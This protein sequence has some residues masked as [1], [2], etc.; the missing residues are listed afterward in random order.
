[1][2]KQPKKSRKKKSEFDSPWKAIIDLYFK[3]FMALCWPEKHAIID[4][5]KGYTMLDKDLIKIDKNAA[6]SN[7]CVD[8]LIEIHCI[9]GEVTYLILHLE[10]Q[11]NAH[12]NFEQRMFQ[13][14]CRLRELYNK[15]IAS[16]AVLIDANPDW[17]PNSYREEVWGSSLEMIFPIVKMTDY[18]DRIAELQLSSNRFAHV[19]LAQLAL[20]KKEEPE[21]RLSTKFELTRNL[22]KLGW[23]G[24]DV[25]SLYK[26]IDWVITLPS[27]LDLVYNDRVMKIEKELKVEYVTTAE[28]VGIQKGLQ[29]AVEQIVAAEHVGVQKGIQQGVQQGVQQGESAVVLH[30]L[31]KKFADVPSSYRERITQMDASTLLKLSEQILFSQS[32]EDVFKH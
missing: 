27:E 2:S 5:H 12:I 23:S 31:E 11:R 21:A 1:M 18:Q 14:R 13:Y 26:F 9:D 16:L 25:R 28:R 22:Y 3:D 19:I 17:R 15:P 29:R 32:L 6:I 8:K 4:W 24:E 30:L 20:N 10:I 7:L